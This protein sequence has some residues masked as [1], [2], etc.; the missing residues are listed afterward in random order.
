MIPTDHPRIA[1]RFRAIFG[2]AAFLGSVA[3]LVLLSQ[4]IAPDI[5]L[6]VGVLAI[7]SAFVSMFLWRPG[8]IDARTVLLV[9]MLGHAMALFGVTLFE[10]DFYRF[11]WDGWRVLEVGTPYGIPPADFFEDTAVPPAMQNLLEWVNYPDFPTIYGPVLQ[12]LFA[13]VA[14]FFGPDEIGLRI[15]FALAS[16]ILSAL[17][18]KRHSPERVALFAWN[19][20]I[21]AESTLHLHPDILLALALFGSLIAGRRHPVIAGI[22][23]GLSAGVKIVAFAAWPV[24]LRLRPSAL[25]S[26]IATLSVLYGVFAIQGLGVGLDSTEIF[27]TQWYFNAFA[28]EPLLHIFGPTWG[29]IATLAIAGI[30]VVWMHASARE[31][32]RVPLAAIFGV[33]LLFAPAL[34]VWYLL[35]LLPFALDRREVWPY[36]ASAVLPLAYLTGLNLEDYTLEEFEVHPWA[37]RLEWTLIGAA[38]AFDIWRERQ[39]G[40]GHKPKQTPIT[41]PKVSVVIPALNEEASIGPTVSGILGVNPRGLI[42]IVV[43]DNGST[44][45][46]AVRAKAAGARVVSQPE[47]GYG[48]ACLAAISALDDQTNIILFMDA[49]L[50]DVPEEAAKLIAPIIAG[51]ADLVIGSRALGTVEKGAM[52]GPQKFG[53]WLAPT[54]VRLIWGVRYTDL[55]PFRAIRRTALEQLAMADRDFGWTIEM[56][57]R[58]A[59]IGLRIKEHPACYRKRIGVSKISGTIRGVFLAGWKILFVIAREA[60]GDFDRSS[61]KRANTDLE[62]A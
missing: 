25:I 16:L 44:D 5:R 54:L 38:I 4:Q 8:V 21:V 9:A 18:L 55:G 35:W 57:V 26:A 40:S 60:F 7:G 33:I 32:D 48:A 20:L 37:L 34:N 6:Y 43:T 24:L 51:D 3:V 49:D 10:D 42:E 2:A 23:L 17:L 56:Q 27:A 15:A 14:F 41:N 45:Q 53:N 13:M 30:L 22:C 62:K 36:V 50:S 11:I 52:S 47:R 29:R 46:T 58:A 31:F 12:L 61:S 1:S 39:R 28:F 19:P 59:K